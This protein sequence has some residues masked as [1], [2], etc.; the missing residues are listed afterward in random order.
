MTETASSATAS[1]VR[2][3]EEDDHST[4]LSMNRWCSFRKLAPE[5]DIFLAKS[6]GKDISNTVFV[7]Q[8][9]I[10]HTF[11]LDSA[12]VTG[13][14]L[15]KTI[16]G[17]SLRKALRATPLDNQNESGSNSKSR[18]KEKDKDQ[19][20]VYLLSAEASVLR[21]GTHD[22][23][24]VFTV[25]MWDGEKHRLCNA[26]A[27]FVDNEFVRGAVL[28]VGAFVRSSGENVA[29]RL[30]TLSNDINAAGYVSGAH[31]FKKQV[32]HDA[33]GV[34]DTIADATGETGIRFDLRVHNDS[35]RRNS[36]DALSTKH[37]FI[38]VKFELH[39]LVNDAV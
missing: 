12:E 14:T 28:P 20:R 38:T 11:D 6:L 35:L 34:I 26:P 31:D 33:S 36:G 29:V 9:S 18:E 8:L 1:A 23:R 27:L 22:C 13:R 3:E 17:V 16:D 7:K 5:L 24:S 25:D 37:H 19:V 4:E 2:H 21:F 39:F 30:P 10:V 32:E 15:S